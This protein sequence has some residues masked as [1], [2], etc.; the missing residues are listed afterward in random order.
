MH[1]LWLAQGLPEDA[2]E[3]DLYKLFE[4]VPGVMAV[5][6]VRDRHSQKC[7]GFAYLVSGGGQGAR[8]SGL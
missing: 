4:P 8:G 2:E 3:A 1:T 6:V 5:R 7:R